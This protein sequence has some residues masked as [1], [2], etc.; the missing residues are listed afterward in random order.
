MLRP[1][2]IVA[3]TRTRAVPPARIVARTPARIVARTPARIVARTQ[4]AAS[5]RDLGE[6]ERGGDHRHIGA[7]FA[8]GHGGR[9][10]AQRGIDKRA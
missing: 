5:L 1:Y 7:A 4:H 8:A 10:Q 9:G 2:R 6:R 3:R